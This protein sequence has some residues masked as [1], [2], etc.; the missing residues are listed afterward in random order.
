MEKE[1]VWVS[2][3]IVEQVNQLNGTVED[4]E[5]IKKI[6]ELFKREI[7]DY[8]F[9]IEEAVVDLKRQSKKI[10]DALRETFDAENE[11]MYQLWE[12]LNSKQDE[13]RKKITS[14][15]E[16]I[17]NSKADV[18]SLK[19]QISSINLYGVDKLIDMVEK[20][21]NMNERDKE[22]LSYLFNHNPKN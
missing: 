19:N 14:A 10:K 4:V 7:N 2:K 12:E 13:V 18:E 6:F 3:D 17:R 16:L 20:I 22:L 15:A 11:Q 8:S 21:S 5:Q 1:L 9:N